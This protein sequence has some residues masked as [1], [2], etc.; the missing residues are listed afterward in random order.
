MGS[1]WGCDDGP[2]FFSCPDVKQDEG[3]AP[4]H[5]T[6]HGVVFAIFCRGPAV[7][8]RAVSGAHQIVGASRLRRIDLTPTHH[9]LVCACTPTTSPTL[10]P[11]PFQSIPR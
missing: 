5:S 9:A 3:C 8:G 11:P 2:F 1:G 10:P 6:L 7:G 4:R